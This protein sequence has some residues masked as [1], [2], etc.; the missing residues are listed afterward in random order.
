MSD[1]DRI[2]RGP[3]SSDLPSTSE[4]FVPLCAIQLPP[5]PIV[6]QNLDP[7]RALAMRIYQ[8]R[9]VNQTV[10]H[11]FFMPSPNLTTDQ[12]EIVRSGFSQWKSVGI[13]LDFREVNVMS[14]AEI[15]IFHNF[16]TNASNS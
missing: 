7:S 13:G 2:I 11:Y 14:E 12:A 6:P 3:Q 8:Y 1:S 10:I 4:G 9:W 15:R 5:E 16:S